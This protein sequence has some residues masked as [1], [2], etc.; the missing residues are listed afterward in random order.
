MKRALCAL[1]MPTIAT[2]FVVAP[3][4]AV[5]RQHVL[6][7]TRSDLVVTAPQ[8]SSGGES[9][10]SGQKA[11]DLPFSLRLGEVAE[12]TYLLGRPIKYNVTIKNVGQTAVAFPWSED[13]EIIEQTDVSFSQATLA[14]QATDATGRQFLMASVILDGSQHVPG[15]LEIIPPGDEAIVTAEIPIN[16]PTDAAHQ[17]ASASEVQVKA[18]LSM[19]TDPRLRWKPLLSTNSVVLSF[20]AP[21]Y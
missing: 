4:I 20:R 15:S 6:D 9:V 18:I 16:L 13:R 10:V 8:R 1:C 5:Q 3:P 21:G 14:L 2:L 17:I 11:L 12:R 19:K 7:L